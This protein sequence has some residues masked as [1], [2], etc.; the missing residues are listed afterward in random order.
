MKIGILTQPL[1]N[2]YGGLLQNYALQQA[3]IRE[4][5]EPET[6]DNSQKPHPWLKQ[7][8]IFAKD[9][10]RHLMKP[11]LIK[12]PKY[13]PNEREF[14]EISRNSMHF[15]NKYIK[16][17]T[18]FH[19]TEELMN[20]V[21]KGRYAGYVVGS[22]QCWRPMYSGGF[23]KEMFLSFVDGDQQVRR[24]SYAASF[25]TNRWEFSPEMTEACTRLAKQFDCVSVREDSGV[26]LCKD[27]LGVEALHVLDPTMLLSKEDYIKLVEDECEPQSGGN[28]FYYILD[29]ND[30]KNGLINKI[31][32]DLQLTPFTVLPRCQAENRTRK[33]IEHHIEDCV[34][35]S[36]TSWLR[37]FM[38]AKMTVVDSFHGA[39]FSIIFNKPFWVIANAERGNAR[40]SSLLKMFDLEDRLVD[41]SRLS[42]L[43]IN[44]QI[45]WNTVNSILAKKII[46]SKKVFNYLR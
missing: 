37:G 8:V 4:G 42:Q 16:H 20:L 5:F 27:Y 21:A 2:N 32:T 38:D 26:R 23:L 41:P 18:P 28:L 3:L 34:Y 7:K 45:D 6:I 14:A 15:I 11:G 12:A 30:E 36:V 24:I 1:H 39:V 9:Y 13:Q 10:F 43:D 29:P 44:R 40:F 31:A 22:D 17:T 35:P 19:S 33:D 46:E 25:G